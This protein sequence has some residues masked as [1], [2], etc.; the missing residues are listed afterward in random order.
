[1]LYIL[2]AWKKWYTAAAKLRRLRFIRKQITERND[3]Y[4]GGDE[5]NP[6][7]Q[8]EANINDDDNNRNNNICQ[9]DYVFV[10]NDDENGDAY[11]LS[12][13]FGPEQTAVH[14]REFAQAAAPCCPN[15]CMEGR[16]RNA[17]LYELREMEREMEEEVKQAFLDLSK[18]RHAVSKNH[19]EYIE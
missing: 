5:E 12:L 19:V 8:E 16:V 6:V 15:G 1:V 13:Q 9:D 4:D 2:I 18:A 11:I 17:T 3:P 10:N 14:S 7:A